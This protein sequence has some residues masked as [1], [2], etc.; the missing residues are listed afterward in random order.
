M[1]LSVGFTRAHPARPAGGVGSVMLLRRRGAS[2]PATR[3]G[4]FPPTERAPRYRGALRK[5]SN[6]RVV[7]AWPPG[8]SLPCGRLCPASVSFVYRLVENADLPEPPAGGR[9][10]PG[11]GC[12]AVGLGTVENASQL[13]GCAVGRRP[14]QGL[15]VH[16][17]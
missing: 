5:Y 14:V 7:I 12:R 8:G 13:P 3:P 11:E 17:P 15:Q 9:L 4:T 2:G 16:V 6:A 10:R 1:P